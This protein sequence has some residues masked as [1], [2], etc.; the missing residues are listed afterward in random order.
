MS[1]VVIASELHA[2]DCVVDTPKIEFSA[3][4]VLAE[5]FFDNPSDDISDNP[6]DDIQ[7]YHSKLLFVGLRFAESSH[8]NCGFD[9]VFRRA[10]LKIAV[11]PNCLIGCG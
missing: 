1:I 9:L 4:K 2:E 5:R 3:N 7:D 11:A 10:W 8:L 6:S